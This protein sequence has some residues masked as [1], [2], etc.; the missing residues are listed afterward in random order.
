MAVLAGG[1][2]DAGG[3]RQR[4]TMLAIAALGVI[5]LTIAGAFAFQAAGIAPCELCL[6]E[7]LPYYYGT[8][9][10]AVTVAAAA[11]GSRPLAL[12]CFALLTA[13]FLFSAGFGAYHAGVEWGF[14][15]GPD[16]CTGTP[17]HASSSADFLHQLQTVR[18]VRCD[19]V[20]IRILG[21]SLAGWNVVVSLLIVA[22]AVIGFGRMPRTQRPGSASPGGV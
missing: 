16:D 10:G 22:L 6:K 1:T 2:I 5:V 21:L 12:A 20:A 14:W 7:R 18:V 17:A 11:R 8:A 9:L 3:A 4:P 19:A 13:L 15:A